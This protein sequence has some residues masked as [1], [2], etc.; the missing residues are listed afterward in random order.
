MNSDQA[1]A[2]PRSSTSPIPAS[3]EPT[4]ASTVS[5]EFAPPPE[6]ISGRWMRLI[7]IVGPGAVMASVTVGTGETIFAP[8]LGA[9]FGYSILWTVL[10]AVIC[11]GILVYTGGRHLVLT[12][13]HPMQAWDRFPGPRH[14]I[15]I[16]LGAVTII[17]FPFWVAALTGAVANLC[18]WITGQGTLQGWGTGI[19]ATAMLLSMV[20]TYQIVEKV[21]TVFLTLKVL[22]IFVAIM[23]VQPDWLAILAGL[24]VPSIP[25]Y[26]PWVQ[27][28][29]PLMAAQL[30][31]FHIA[32]FLGVV[33]GGVQ[34]Y[35]GY[36]SFM[37]EKRWGVSDR[38]GNGRYILPSGPEQ[39]AR[40]RLW[41]RAPLL[42]VV[43]SFTAVFVMTGCFMVLGAAV[44]HPSMAVP[45]DADL[46]SHQSTFLGLIHPSLVS[47]YK[48]G[49]FIAIFAAIYG[50]F[51]V[52][53]RS[54]Y[55]PLRAVWPRRNWNV[56]YLRIVTT[57]YCGIGA[58][59]LLWSDRRTVALVEVISP[60]T[61]VLGCG[62]WCL[63]M[64][65]VDRRQM[66]A[67]YRMRRGLLL[68]TIV[69]GLLM[70]SLG[71]FTAL[72]RWA[73]GLFS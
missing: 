50:T 56:T 23:I 28:N 17:S 64:V 26:E 30:P 73:P 12:G 65:W 29:Y 18:M 39:L 37:R 25:A 58:I 48:A 7:R 8:R 1:P 52:Y 61:G 69:A 62:L 34:D 36:V 20:Q 49:I 46:Y 27:A 63:A 22:L 21:S 66:P 16:L 4:P 67:A 13:E 70:A 9:V 53:T 59:L 57:L 15:P 40:A 32:V 14:W 41:L 51:E 44:L 11:K 55:E 2:A 6:A 35:T 33:G 38:E 43:F 3:S 5:I 60:L 54:A 10:L 42:D 31:I 45:T 72:N 24:L 47:V 71:L 68:A 19:V